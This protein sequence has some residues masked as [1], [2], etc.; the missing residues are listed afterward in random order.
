VIPRSRLSRGGGRLEPSSVLLSHSFCTPDSDVHRMTWA[1]VTETSIRVLQQKTGTKLTIPLH[2]DL[3]ALLAVAHRDHVT[4][5]NAYYGRPFTVDGFGQWMRDAI[6]LL[7]YLFS[8]NRTD[9]ERLQVG[10]SPKPNAAP[11]RSCRFS[12]TRLWPKPS[13]IFARPIR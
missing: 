6:V 8:A 13:G 1:D 5:L 11:T 2:R 12:V 3:I 9:S 7:G 10:V 4:I